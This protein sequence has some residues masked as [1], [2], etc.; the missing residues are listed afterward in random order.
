MSVLLLNSCYEPIQMVSTKKAIKLL[1]RGVATVEKYSDTVWKTVSQEFVLP[2][3]L[4]LLNFYTIPNRL[5]RL[6][7]KNLMARDNWSCQ[8]CNKKLS[9]TSGTVD[10]VVPKSRGGVSAWENLVAACVKCNTKKAN[11]TPSE[12]GMELVSKRVPKL[13]YKAILRNHGADKEQWREYLF[14]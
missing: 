6:S 2:T 9:A 7:K 8:Y 1:V 11:R 12:A 5:Y 13:N 3:V 10:H 14:F 4:R